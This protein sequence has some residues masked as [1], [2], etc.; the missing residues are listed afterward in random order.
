VFSA[1]YFSAGDMVDTVAI[2]S[3]VEAGDQIAAEDLGVVRVGTGTASLRTVDASERDAYVGR[4]A[5][6]D[7][8][9]G[10]LLSPGQVQDVELRAVTDDEAI[11]A[12]LTAAGLSPSTLG[13][14]GDVFIVVRPAQGSD[15]V[16]ARFDGWAYR[17]D[18]EP[19][20]SGDRPIEVVVNRDD[21]AA[22]SAA[23]ADGR[24]TVV[25]LEG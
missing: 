24:A 5:A 25:A 14:G 17:V 3:S 2:V 23:S 4:V 8:T 6:T 7:L 13:L 12:V 18:L 22:I 19:L 21:A 15:E 9:E 10:S 20:T 16:V 1:L 11:V